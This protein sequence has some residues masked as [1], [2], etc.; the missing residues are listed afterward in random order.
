MKNHTKEKIRETAK[1][2]ASRGIFDNSCA[3]TGIERHAYSEAWSA[4]DAEKA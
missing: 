4:A 1:I 3:R 2:H